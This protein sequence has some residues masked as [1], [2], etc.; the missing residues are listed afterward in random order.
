MTLFH[1]EISNLPFDKIQDVTINVRGLIATFLKFGDIR[2]QTAAE[3]SEDY[4]MNKVEN[5]DKVR[6]VIFEQHNKQIER[7][8]EV[9]IVDQSK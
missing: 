1:R 2:V 7:I 8:Q 3:H 4:M 6:Q 5:P 9:K